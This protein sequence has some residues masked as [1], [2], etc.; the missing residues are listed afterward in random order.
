[1]EAMTALERLGR[2]GGNVVDETRGFKNRELGGHIP[3]GGDEVFSF[4]IEH[5]SEHPI[6]VCALVENLFAGL[7]LMARTVLSAQPKAIALPS[8][9]QLAP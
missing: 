8:G 3:C 9:D 6:G 1:M 2:D 4:H 5:R 7:A